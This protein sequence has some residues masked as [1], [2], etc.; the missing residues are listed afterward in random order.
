MTELER[1]LREAIE[2]N[3]AKPADP[4]WFVTGDGRENLKTRPHHVQPDET[5]MP[6]VREYCEAMSVRLAVTTGYYSAPNAP[7]PG[8]G[9]LCV[10]A[11]NEAGHNS[12]QVDLLDLIDWV[13][14]NRPE[15]LA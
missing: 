1:L 3:R 2:K 14:L 15:L 13:K 6:G 5:E 8:A 7:R 12:T 11:Y 9:R 4:D 10:V